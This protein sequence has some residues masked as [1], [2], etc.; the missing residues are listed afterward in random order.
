MH[1][2][3][4]E[5]KFV[6]IIM[7]KEDGLCQVSCIAKKGTCF[8]FEIPGSAPDECHGSSE[9]TIINGCF[10][11]QKVHHAKEPSLLNDTICSTSLVM[12]GSPYM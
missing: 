9:K 10:G 5:G 7:S 4:T 2:L 12:V 11:T 6:R 3:D 8:C 1:L